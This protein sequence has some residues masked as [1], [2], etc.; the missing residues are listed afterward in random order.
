MHWIAATFGLYMRGFE[1]CLVI[2]KDTRVGWPIESLQPKPSPLRQKFAFHPQ[3]SNAQLS[4][5]LE[6][7]CRHLWRQHPTT[8]YFWCFITALS[9]IYVYI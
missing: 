4:S 1:M 6:G 7:K 2:D 8:P 3:G 5:A 9:H